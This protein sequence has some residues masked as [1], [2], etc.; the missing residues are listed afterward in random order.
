MA[1]V[2]RIGKSKTFKIEFTHFKTKKRASILISKTNLK[3]VHVFRVHI[4]RILAHKKSGQPLENETAVW[5]KN[6]PDDYTAKL[7]HHGLIEQ[8]KKIQL[9]NFVR[10]IFLNR[11]DVQNSTIDIWNQTIKN[12]YDFFGEGLSIS[13]IS[14]GRAEQFYQ[15]LK[16]LGLSCATI[17]KRIGFCK[18]IFNTAIKH[19]FITQNPFRGIKPPK[20]KSSDRQHYVDPATTLK[21]MENASRDW[22]IIIAL[23]RFG[24]LR[25]PSEV[26][27]LR[28]DHI[29]WQNNRITLASPKTK[30][31]PG[32][33]TRV[34]P[35]FSAL[36]P[37]LEEAKASA[38]EGQSH[39]VGG[40][41]LNKSRCD[42]RWRNCNI[43]KPMETLVR[44]AG[45]DLWPRLFHNLRSS[46]ETDLLD[47]FPPQ[48][49][50]SWLGHSVEVAMEHYAQTTPYHFMAAVGVCPEPN[51]QHISQQQA[52]ATHG[53][54][55]QINIIKPDNLL[56][57]AKKCK[58][59][60]SAAKPVKAEE[61]GFEPPVEFPPHS[62]SSAAQSAALSPLRMRCEQVS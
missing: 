54:D 44:N 31:Y 15:N 33:E 20:G 6:L 49:V 23:C 39:V 42:K 51:P 37:F 59:T 28:W 2:S 18:T 41:Y 22:R 43:R 62:I 4:E 25:C 8:T 61:G 12:L 48:T 32:K 10:T 55:R 21:V 45:F 38:L 56:D 36:R 9:G 46:F 50:A 17:S 35:L 19:E 7:A 26:L 40:N 58:D 30:R 29:D 14:A 57:Y 5:I 3:Y 47:K 53:A 34:M 16:S 27:S 11:K 1:S 24:G 60:Q 52:S 13:D